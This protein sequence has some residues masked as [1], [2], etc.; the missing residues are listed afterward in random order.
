[1][2]RQATIFDGD[3]NAERVTLPEPFY[4]EFGVRPS[5]P[6][7]YTGSWIIAMYYGP[8][9]GRCFLETYSIWDAGDGSIIGTRIEEV[10]KPELLARC[11]RVS[12]EPPDGLLAARRNTIID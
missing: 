4:G 12:C 9:S 8:R 6:E 1:M 5:G 3:G 7:D 10:T 2:K 11:K